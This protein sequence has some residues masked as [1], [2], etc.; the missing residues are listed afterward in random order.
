MTNRY[1]PSACV[2]IWA[3]AACVG[4]GCDDPGSAT[5]A[6]NSE[7]A[8][9]RG[10]P[11]PPASKPAACS[12]ERKL[13]NPENV[14]LFPS[15]AGTFCLD[16]AGSD[17]AYGKGAAK[18]LP[19]ICNLFDGE[20]D[21]Y[22]SG[23]VLRVVEARYVDGEGSGAT[24]DVYLSMYKSPEAAYAMF[25]KRVVGDLDPAHPD[26]AKP[27]A[28]GGVA[29]LGIGNAYLWRGAHLAEITYNDAA[30]N[31][32]AEI[33]QRANAL[34]PGLVESFGAKLPGDTKLPVSAA[35]LPQE[36]RLKL[37]LR[38]VNKEIL[39]F[40]GTGGG[41]FG[42]YR[43]G[44]VRWRV[45]SVAKGDAQQAKDALGTFSKAAGAAAE[46][47]IGDSATRFM[48]APTGL[49]ETEW[50]VARKGSWVVGIG[51]EDRALRAGMS[52]EEH[53]AKTL[54]MKAKRSTL[55]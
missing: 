41:A 51:D 38:F 37:G 9:R 45:L 31:T 1:T 14:T 48:I 42:Y 33:R 15:E 29:A 49:P 54:D 11:P 7:A 10:Q 28:G 47:G 36:H 19:D 16:P 46:K 52:P 18:P 30:A 20:C 39:G 6:S 25:T 55:R 26:M 21:I 13:N 53:R 22:L 2:T 35:K 5:S 32:E 17:R 12:G 40:K 8:P 44:E 24:I 50:L 43:D 34:L 3:L 4:G 27:T 23:G